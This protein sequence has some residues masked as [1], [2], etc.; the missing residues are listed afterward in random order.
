[1]SVYIRAQANGTMA[2]FT[3][4][5][6][7]DLR[8]ASTHSQSPLEAIPSQTVHLPTLGELSSVGDELLQLGHDT[9][10]EMSLAAI[11]PALETNMRRARR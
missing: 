3:A 9:L 7:A 2:S 11:V 1:M 10:F 4:A 6:E 8:N 5:R